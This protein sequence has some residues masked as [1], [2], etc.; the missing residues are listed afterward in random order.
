MVDAS[1]AS[2]LRVGL[3][4]KENACRLR[5]L[6]LCLVVLGLTWRLS[7]YLLRFP[8]WGD[9]AMLLENYL[10]R[11]Y[12]DLLGPIGNCQVAPLLFHWVELTII[13][14]L[15]TGELS[16]RLPPLLA[17]VSS[18]GLFWWLARVTLPPLARTL[19]VGTLAVSV[20]PAHM[21]ALAKPYAGDLLFSLLLLLPAVYWWRQPA[22]R[23]PL[24]VLVVVL[25]VALLASYP[26]V[27][28]G[29]AVSVALLPLVWRGRDPRTWALF[30]LFNV[31]LVGTFVAHY[32]LVG[33]S[34][35]SAPLRL[36]GGTTA[37]EMQRFWHHCGAFPPPGLVGF[38]KWFLAANT[39]QMAGYPWGGGKGGSTLTILLALIGL[40]Q[41]YRGGQRPLV[42]VVV[43]A[44][45]LGMAAALLHR[46]PYGAACRL[47]QHLAPCYCLLAGVGAA[48]LLGRLK[49]NTRWKA[50]LALGGGLA[51]IPVVGM[52]CD[53]LHPYRDEEALW[54][55]QVT[56]RLMARTGD[57]PILVAQAPPLVSPV[58]E[59]QMSTQ[60]HHVIWAHHVDWAQ[61]GRES[62]SLWTV[63]FTFGSPS[64]LEQAVIHRLLAR[65]GRRWRCVEKT[66]SVLPI[67]N[68]PTQSCRAYHW[69]C[70]DIGKA[71]LPPN[72]ERCTARREP[73]PPVCPAR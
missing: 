14:W 5:W 53:F 72:R 48:G 19:A 60:G 47:G 51:L 24:V 40:W 3:W 6:A 15:G 32:L 67:P 71:W 23:L 73:R 17:C 22:R 54:A 29:G 36:G 58:F 44:F 66:S 57:D 56:A 70:D 28:I 27:F 34:Q 1:S 46:Y 49:D 13:R 45:G 33:K 31:L 63:S 50:I 4:E 35:M 37:D 12:L 42:I 38:L 8:V 41:L 61:H 2:R 55:R 30:A 16:V 26:A 69:V 25:P 20:W 65:C 21:G 59:W 62:S 11:G 39:G 68:E 10:G 52:A 43:V 7:R 64:P 18:L 9:E